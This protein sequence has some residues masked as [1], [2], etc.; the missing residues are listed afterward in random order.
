[1][2]AAYGRDGR[3]GSLSGHA[4]HV[5][6][7]L[8]GAAL[9][10]LFKAVAALQGRVEHLHHHAYLVNA[11]AAWMEQHGAR[12][13]AAE[14]FERWWKWCTGRELTDQET[15]RFNGAIRGKGEISDESARNSRL[16]DAIGALNA[17]SGRHVYNIRKAVPPSLFALPAWLGHDDPLKDDDA[18]RSVLRLV[19]VDLF[20]FDDTRYRA[21]L[22][23]LGLTPPEPDESAD[24]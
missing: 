12:P 22:D 6:A 4:A 24:E 17:M 14:A 8:F 13:D 20:G 9:D 19:I 16:A 11:A 5:D 1:M 10:R 21:M 18:R 15:E 3:S 2:A 23:V 7:R